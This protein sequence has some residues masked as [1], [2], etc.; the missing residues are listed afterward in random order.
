[1][2]EI[3]TLKTA[4]KMRAM[5]MYNWAEREPDQAGLIVTFSV[6]G[7]AKP[8]WFSDGQWVMLLS[9]NEDRSKLN[10]AKFDPS[11][12][13]L[14]GIDWMYCPENWRPVCGSLD[15]Y[16]GWN[17]DM[18]PALDYSSCLVV[19]NDEE[20]PV[21]GVR[22]AASNPDDEWFDLNSGQRLV[23]VRCWMPSPERP[24]SLDPAFVGKE[25]GEGK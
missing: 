4:Q 1:M 16:D 6:F 5:Y 9:E 15:G 22:L 7:M 21:F 25:G 24:L 14:K 10:R 8:M 12:A 11:D 20:S 18:R 17:W 23:E 19:A 13:V 3:L 2:S